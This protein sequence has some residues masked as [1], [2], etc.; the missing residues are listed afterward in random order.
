MPPSES[1]HPSGEDEPFEPSLWVPVETDFPP[2]P[3]EDDAII[4]E[5]TRLTNE[6]VRLSHTNRTAD[7]E[8]LLRSALTLAEEKLGASHASTAICL[9]N[10]GEFLSRNRRFDEAEPILRRALAIKEQLHGAD[11]LETATSTLR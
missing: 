2:L 6:G 8:S 9:N 5:V 10:L 4:A 3:N 7:A 1:P 11:H